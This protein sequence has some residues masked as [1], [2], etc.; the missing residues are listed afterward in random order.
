MEKVAND[1]HKLIHRLL[2]KYGPACVYCLEPLS[3]ANATVDHYVPRAAGGSN[4]IDNLRPAC[5]P[6]NNWKADRV[7]NPDGSIPPKKIRIRVHK[8]QR[9]S[10]CMICSS[11]RRLAA[12]QT[13]WQCNTGPQPE[14]RPQY[15]KVK[16]WL[17]DHDEFWCI[18]CCLMTEPER[19]IMSLKALGMRQDDAEFSVSHEIIQEGV[20]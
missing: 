10:V 16:T 3:E 9:P 6:C 5:F 11:G 8:G 17:C 20:A 18:A 7:P 4:H 13:C 15:L 1:R 12:G 14:V 19:E 2:R